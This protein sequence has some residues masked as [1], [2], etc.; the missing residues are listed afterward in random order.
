M[1]GRRVSIESF[2]SRG[3]GDSPGDVSCSAAEVRWRLGARGA[4][5]QG[6]GAT[7]SHQRRGGSALRRA[8]AAARSLCSGRR[9]VLG[10]L[11]P[12]AGVGGLAPLMSVGVLCWL[13]FRWLWRLLA[14][15]EPEL[16]IERVEVAS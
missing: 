8:R 16:E 14:E 2:V 7:A 4:D 12:P 6:D 13:E 3:G 1:H 10:W 11:C 5:L 9:G 15:I